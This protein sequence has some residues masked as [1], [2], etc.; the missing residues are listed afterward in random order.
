MGLRQISYADVVCDCSCME[1]K[2]LSKIL[3]GCFGGDR[4]RLC[5][6]E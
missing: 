2:F 6:I 1:S 3:G 4:E 5:E